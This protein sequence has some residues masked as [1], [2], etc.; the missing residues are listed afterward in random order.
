MKAS[1]QGIGDRA[2][3]L[4]N[5]RR[6]LDGEPLAA[7]IQAREILNVDPLDAEALRLLASALRRLGKDGE[8][9]TV[10]LEAVAASAG[11][12]VLIDAAAAMAQDRLPDAEQLLRPH[13]QLAPDDVAAIAMLA[14]IANRVG[15]YAEA[16][17]L[18]RRALHLAPAFN[19]ARLGLATVLFRQF[20]PDESTAELDEVLRREPDNVPAHVAKGGTLGQTGEYQQA[21]DLYE[22]ASRR[23]PGSALI[24]LSYGHVLKTVGR[25]D[26]AIV[27]YRRVIALG[28]N[29]GEAWWSIANLKTTRLDEDD[30]SAMTAALGNDS[31]DALDRV[32]L[33]FALGKASEDLGQFEQSFRH[34][35]EANR[36]R[37]AM[38]AYN[39]DTITAD[40]DRA[41]NFFT[42]AFF[43]SRAG[44]GCRSGDPIFI[45][46]M[47]RAGSTLIEQILASHSMIEGTAEL[48][49]I[50]ALV[51]GV[52]AQRWRQGGASYPQVLN[53]LGAADFEALGIDYLRR[54][55]LHRKTSRPYF[56]DK[57]PNNWMD[58][59]FI[60]LILPNAKIIDTR[61]D[62][63]ACCLSN[64]KQHFAQGQAFS[65]DQTELGRYYR[66]Y[67]RL[68]NHFDAALPGHVYRLA[69]EKLIDT[70]EGAVR[71]LLEYLGLPFE[72]ACLRF[73]ENDRAVRTA[74]SEQVRQP[75]NRAGLDRWRDYEGWLGPLKEA[76][77]RE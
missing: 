8:A 59:G 30:I 27:A 36:T 6:L 39:P 3:A 48:P 49:Y 16:E 51:R 54:A 2:Q 14:E 75:I 35:A 52:I 45:V 28:V 66:D 62:P 12:P 55:S 47:P 21:I 68:L 67:H 44:Q 31:L 43:A 10:E 53:Q 73:Y 64:F 13:L 38:L 19:E 4:A 40:V 56:I 61:R 46:G 71:G 65:Y 69:Y 17:K 32:N 5:G 7:A 25:V 77:G 70:P 15:I 50:P 72:P 57:L 42:P 37:R 41:C 76:L 9:E 74:S 20:R 58:I 63:V 23:M 1:F 33:R 60:R 34:Y 24:W 11:T 18:F 22:V 29:A 26:E